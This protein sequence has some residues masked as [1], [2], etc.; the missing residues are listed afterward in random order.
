MMMAAAVFVV[1]FGQLGAN[2]MLLTVASTICGFF[3]SAGAAGIYPL[4]ASNFPTEV[5]AGGTGVVVAIGRGGAV[6]GPVITGYLLQANVPLAQV[7]MLISLGS[8]S[9]A[10]S[11]WLLG[12]D[13]CASA[14]H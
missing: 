12:S 6:A 9:A 5:R 1:L 7:A 4:I 14:A 13:S 2:L 3:N 10:L 11:I 8:V